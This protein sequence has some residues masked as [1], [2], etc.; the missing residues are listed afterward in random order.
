LLSVIVPTYNERDNVAELI[1]QTLRA[2]DRCDEPAELLIVDDDSPDGTAELVRSIAAERSEEGRV[3]VLLRTQDRGLA[4]A[5]VA[6]FE[7]ARGDVLAVMDA[8]LSH[9]PELLP[10]LLGAV[11]EH[12]A[13]MAFASRYVAGGGTEGWPLIRRVISR[14]ACLL[15]RGLTSVRDIT[16][17]FFA[18]RRSCVEGRD[19]KPRGYK[20]GLEILAGLTHPHV[21]EVPFVFRD[22][23]YG[24]SKLSG[25]VMAAYL[26]Q[27]ATLY[28]ARFPVIVGYLQFAMV[29]L[30]G[31]LVDAAVFGFGYY[32]IGLQT[33]GTETGGF[34]AQTLSFLVAA[35][36]NFA[37]NSVWTF[38]EH[39][40][41][42]R[43]DIFIAVSA[44]GFVIRSVVFAVVVALA[45]A[46]A[47]AL[48]AVMRAVSP[49]Q[50][51]L[52]LGIVAGS[53]WNYYGSRRWAFRGEPQPE[54]PLPRPE[55]LRAGTVAALAFVVVALI[56]LVWAAAMPLVFDEAY[57]WQWS[58]HLAW[59]YYDHPPMIAYLIAGGVRLLGAQELGVRLVPLVLSLAVPWMIHHLARLYWGPT[60]A[61]P[62]ALATA[63]AVP[64]FS[65][66]SVVATPDTPLIFFWTA[67]VLLALR[68]TRTGHTVDWLL[69]GICS[70]LGMLSKYP[71]ALIYP[72]L[73]AALL[74][75]QRGRMALKR[76]GPYLGVLLSWIVIIPLILWQ[77]GQTSG[78][79][80]FQ[81]QHGLGPAAGTSAQVDA[82][83]SFATF[84][85]GQLGVVTPILFVL[86]VLALIR[87]VRQLRAT[88]A[89]AQ[90][91][92]PLAKREILPFLLYPL[93][94]PLLVFGLASLLAKS[95]PNWMAPAYV[96]GLVLLG[97]E[98]LRQTRRGSARWRRLTAWTGFA[99]AAIVSTYVHLES[100]VPLVPY[101]GGVLT[102]TAGNREL[103]AWAGAL[104][105]ANGGDVRVLAAN[106]KLASVLAF[107]MPGHPQT[108]SPFERKSGSAYLAWQRAPE[109]GAPALYFCHAED[110]PELK[111]LFSD[112]RT[113]GKDVT[114]RR[115]QTVRTTWA[116]IG[117]LRQDAFTQ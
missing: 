14:G 58:R 65:V 116:F 5:V 75:S 72:A 90:S 21:V 29:G 42:A 32:Y 69:V 71:M 26:L 77:L 33:L 45:G 40:R 80:L 79:V 44:F 2:F 12:D 98:L 85:G 70:G 34:I 102:Q 1:E 86:L 22:R 31:M 83:S 17:G 61:A 101:K 112:Y 41:G 67:T 54:L 106:Y 66:G 89:P 84:V 100:L 91:P 38:R 87:A 24:E 64:L 103:G 35:V 108:E 57:Y 88:P 16:S 81:L 82:L 95:Q 97:G 113:L 109:A 78:G 111:R 107:Y 10:E 19:I 8:D 96:T 25:S 63:L 110:C 51:A 39:A 4:K 55:A 59:G 15:A 20:I 30:L 76:P 93:L 9:P 115:G 114:Y 47:G 74:S 11:R 60:A 6:G 68:A 56:K 27:L 62:W 48:G 3:R 117:N 99:L 28:R 73:L 13:D 18:L 105:E 53:L 36:F 94:V 50:V 49:E 92:A 104:R 46:D 7:A 23:R 37:L 52:V 43:L